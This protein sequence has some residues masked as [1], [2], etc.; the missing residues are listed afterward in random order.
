MNTTPNHMKKV[1]LFLVVAL[2]FGIDAKAQ[3]DTVVVIGQKM[4]GTAMS[5]PALHFD[6]SVF[7]Y[8]FSGDETH[9]CVSYRNLSKDGKSWKNNGKISYINFKEHRELWNKSINY[10]SQSAMCVKSGVLFSDVNNIFY[11]DNAGGEPWSNVSSLVQINDSLNLVFGYDYMFPNR[12][13]AYSLTDG[14]ELWKT[15]VSHDYGWSD[16]IDLSPSKKLVVAD[17]LY[18]INLSTGET[19]EYPLKVGKPDVGRMILQGL[20]MAAAAGV[21]AAV[22]GSQYYYTPVTIKNNVINGMV[23]NIWLNDSVCYIA[24][25]EKVSCVD[26]LLKSK[27]TCEIPDN[28]ASHSELLVNGDRLYMLNMGYGLK[29]GYRRVNRGKPFLASYDIHTGK[30]IFMNM[31]SLKKDMIEGAIAT[32]DAFFMLFDDGLAYQN[33][34]DTTVSRHSWDVEKYGKLYQFVTDTVYAIDSIKGNFTPVYFDGVNCPVYSDNGHLYVVDKDLNIKTDYPEN[35]IYTP[36]VRMKDYFCV[37]KDDDFWFIHKLGLPV[38]HFNTV[39]RHGEIIGK[40]L[41][42]LTDK[43]D[44]LF[45]DLDKAIN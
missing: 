27:W 44:L 24:D 8:N 39:V 28:L 38:I 30:Q 34:V 43:N 9:L 19:L 35:L 29:D 32:N 41:T 14:T 26:T 12:L 25:R 21:G 13:R 45:I 20:A 42:L 6:K 1:I 36:C 37:N 16:Q 31:F 17:N 3:K 4:D 23:S 40:K 18:C 15:K 2:S 10:R 33:V 11:K 5:V 22:T 7:T